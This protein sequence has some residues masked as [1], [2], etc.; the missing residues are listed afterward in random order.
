MSN[1]I[2]VLNAIKDF[3]NGLFSMP[4]FS[5][6]FGIIVTH[7]F[8]SLR[9][10]NKR[11]HDDKLFII[12]MSV[13][14]IFTI[15]SEIAEKLINF[16]NVLNSLYHKKDYDCLLILKEKLEELSSCQ[17]KAYIFMNDKTNNNFEKLMTDLY[18]FAKKN[19]FTK[20]SIKKA[21]DLYA[22]HK[23]DVLTAIEEYSGAAAAHNFII[24]NLKIK[25]KRNKP[26]TS[27]QNSTSSSS[28]QNGSP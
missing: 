9:E 23:A 6:I 27:S 15:S 4:V 19:I 5:A 28:D 12:N 16:N 10:I 18:S 22:S 1:F 20:D 11:K 7:F 17:M 2:Y 14:K 25:R 13:E 24:K 26:M 3:I 21:Q 8:I